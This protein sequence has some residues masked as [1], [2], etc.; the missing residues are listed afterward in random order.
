MKYCF[1]RFPDFKIKALTL[2]Y[3][4]GVS[5]DK[6]LIEIMS[7]Y[8]LKCTFNICSGLFP[9]EEGGRCLSEKEAFSLY[10]ASGHEVAVHGEKHLPLAAIDSASVFNEIF[11][12]RKNL[13]KLFDRAVHGMAYAYG[14]YSDTVV[15]IARL[16]GIHY[17]RTVDTREDFSIP[18]DWLRMP[19]TCHHREPRLMELAKK[20]LEEPEG[21]FWKKRPKLFYLWGHSYE[22]EDRN[23]WHIIEEFAK[24]VGN[25]EDVWY[26]TNGEIYEYVQAYDRLQF[27]ADRTRVYNPSILD[28]YICYFGKNYLIPSGVTVQLV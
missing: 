19:A 9:K 4:D 23:E 11:S 21:G 25:R 1:L 27:N 14:S 26:A 28:V 20:F 18:T 17:A 10:S 13:E 15:E 5:Y 7:K 22:F 6:K 2:S 24:L 12:D 8:R 3:D 16:C